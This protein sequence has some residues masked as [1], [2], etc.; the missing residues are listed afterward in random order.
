[1]IYRKTQ[2]AGGQYADGT[3]TRYEVECVRSIRV[4]GR[5][6]EGWTE[7]ESFQA[8]LDA[9][10]LHHVEDELAETLAQE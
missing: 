9:W 8:A 1:M 7:F 6:N 3:G 10:G 2:D 5:Q 4:G